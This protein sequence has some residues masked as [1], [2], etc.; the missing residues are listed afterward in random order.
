[1][2]EEEVVKQN[3]RLVLRDFASSAFVVTGLFLSVSSFIY[4]AGYYLAGY[5]LYGK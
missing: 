5:T 2:G 4:D 1:V 3:T